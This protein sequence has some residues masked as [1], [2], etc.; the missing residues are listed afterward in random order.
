MASAT[1]AEI[2]QAAAMF[3]T[4]SNAKAQAERDAGQS[5]KRVA[6][7]QQ[8]DL[9]AQNVLAERTRELGFARQNL[10][11]VLTRV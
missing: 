4:A 5:A 11:N 1:D 10:I 3:M 9:T 2:A 8:T 6:D 7:A